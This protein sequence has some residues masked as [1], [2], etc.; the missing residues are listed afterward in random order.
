[1][2]EAMSVSHILKHKGRDVIT[3]SPNETVQSVAETL[4]KKRIGAVVISS[5]NGKI[6]GIVSERDIVRAVGEHG[7]GALA[8]PVSSIMTANVKHCSD[9]DSETELM[10]LMTQHRIRHLPVVAGG[11]LSGM[12][13]IGDVVKFRIEQIERDA[14]DMKAYISGAA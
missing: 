6:D 4:G 12:I 2:E 13:S 5:G 3:A 9:D 8:K 14:E 7:A 10:A 11:K 1:M